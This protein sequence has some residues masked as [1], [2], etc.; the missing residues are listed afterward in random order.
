MKTEITRK[1]RDSKWPGIKWEQ[2]LPVRYEADVAVIGGGIAGVC[3]A[4]AA[5]ASGVSVIL[6]ERFAATGG[7]LTTGG[8]ANFSG[9]TRGLGEV[10]DEIIDERI[11]LSLRACSMLALQYLNDIVRQT[12]SGRIARRGR[13]P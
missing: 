5:A 1:E 2:D 9:D 11:T 8:V 7:V 3:A 4:C 6:V 13:K 12:D 10:F